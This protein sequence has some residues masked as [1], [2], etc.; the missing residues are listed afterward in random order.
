MGNST[1]N[2]FPLFQLIDPFSG[3]LSGV[4]GEIDGKPDAVM[5][6]VCKEFKNRSL[7]YE[8]LFLGHVALTEP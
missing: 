4:S 6:G 7:G 3:I 5:V 2:P 1:S 8:C